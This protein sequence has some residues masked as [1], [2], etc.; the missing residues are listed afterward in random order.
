MTESGMS[1]DVIA[2]MVNALSP[3]F[4]SCDALPK[5]TVTKDSQPLNALSLI[6]VTAAGMMTKRRPVI[7]NAFLPIDVRELGRSTDFKA[8]QPINAASG[9]VSAPAGIVTSPLTSGVIKQE[10]VVLVPNW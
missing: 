9:I 1:I 10:H 2:V 8:V 6:M 5:V 3:I 7:G 4:V